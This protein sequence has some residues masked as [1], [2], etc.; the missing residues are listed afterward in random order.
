MSEAEKSGLEAVIDTARVGRFQIMVFVLCGLMA[1]IDGFDT[2]SIAFVAPEIAVRW[3]ISADLFGPIFGAGLL[4]GQLGAMVFGVLGDRY[5]RRPAL[6]CAVPLFMA[7]SFA[8]AFATSVPELAALRFLTGLGLGGAIPSIIAITSE[9]APLR[10]RNSIVAFMWCGYPF[11]AV[12]GGIASAHLIPVFGWESVFIVGAVVPLVLL[13]FVWR[14]VPESA[15]FLAIRQDRAAVLRLLGRMGLADRW[16]GDLAAGP[17]RPRVPVAS[18]FT[19]GRA[20]GTILLWVALFFSL[21]TTYFLINWLPV[22]ARRTGIGISD[23]VLAVAILNWGSIVG[24]LVLGRLIGRFRPAMVIS[25]GFA[26]GAVAIAAI[27]PFGSSVQV[28]M[29][30][31]FFAGF[32]TLG[33]QVCTIALCAGYYATELR[34]T[35]VGWS[36][37]VSRIGAVIGP[38]LG[39]ILLGGGAPASLLFLFVGTASFCAAMA[40]LAMGLLVLRPSSRQAAAL[41]KD[42]PH[43]ITAS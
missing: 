39:G 13:P 43:H 32:L 4:G 31:A 3:R 30:L 25:L 24:S 21:L 37:G 36:I 29:P 14:L 1:M 7:M 40:V 26:C 18:L 22:I 35:G 5:G 20:A 34:A 9:Y 6:L 15:R 38:V 16:N 10:Q 23:A 42:G 41:P 11:G 17:G 27:G 2:Q 12:V 19:G 33:S 28:L 8:T